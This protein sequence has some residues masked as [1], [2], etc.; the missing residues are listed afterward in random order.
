MR[1][2]RVRACGEELPGA[3]FFQRRGVSF[4]RCVVRKPDSEPAL[5]PSSSC[6]STPEGESHCTCQLWLANQIQENACE[7]LDL[8]SFCE[9]RPCSVQFMSQMGSSLMRHIVHWLRLLHS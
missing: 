1:A 9:L 7:V 3:V 6:V 2:K 8:G 4:L 5:P